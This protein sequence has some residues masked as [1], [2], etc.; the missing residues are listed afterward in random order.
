[1]RV[2]ASK[3]FLLL[4]LSI[5]FSSCNMNSIYDE[6]VV[7][8]ECKWYKDEMAR[9]DLVIN[10]TI[11]LYNFYLK[12][13]NNTDY[14]YSNLYVFLKTEFP[15]NNI[16]RDTIE[17]L[18]ANVEGKWLGKGWGKVKENEF[19]LSSNMRFPLKGKYEFVIQ[20]AMRTD[21]LNGIQNIGIRIAKSE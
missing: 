3:I 18:L 12:I 2:Q 7:I 6:Q 10:D 5:V 19:L 15:N 4:S 11:Q 20:H 13:R 8:E 17:C 1:M 14:R 9:F 21:T 16:S